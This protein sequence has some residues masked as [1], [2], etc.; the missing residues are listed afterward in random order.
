VV[1][2]TTVTAL[3]QLPIC[4]WPI[5]MFPSF[6]YVFG[7]VRCLTLHL[8][9]SCTIC[10]ISFLLKNMKMIFGVLH[11]ITDEIAKF[12]IKIDVMEITLFDHY[13]YFKLS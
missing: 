13:M 11:V 2:V 9:A 4:N 6:D 12:N 5:L 1:C 8:K 3:V 7:I 10:T